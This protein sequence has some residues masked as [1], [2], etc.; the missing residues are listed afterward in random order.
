MLAAENA[1]VTQPAV[2]RPKVSP[3][4]PV[5]GLPAPP[6]AISP[7]YKPLYH[8]QPLPNKALRM[9]HNTK[10]DAARYHS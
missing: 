1:V 10:V 6:G 9:K 8:P 7:I 2:L 4:P 3:F 5:P